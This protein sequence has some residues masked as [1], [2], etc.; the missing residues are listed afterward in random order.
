MRQM[1]EALWAREW[2]DILWGLGW[3]ASHPIDLQVQMDGDG[4]RVWFHTSCGTGTISSSRGILFRDL[5]Q[6]D[7][8]P[9]D[10]VR[11]QLEQAVVEL[12]SYM[13]VVWRGRNTS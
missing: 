2:R 9:E 13:D 5:Y 1:I 11:K 6:R 10:M 8:D 3:F 7:R 4:F 12:M